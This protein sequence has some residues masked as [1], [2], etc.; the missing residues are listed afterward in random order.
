M[1]EAATTPRVPFVFMIESP[2]DEDL[3]NGDYEGHGLLGAQ[4][5]TGCRST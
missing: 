4:S 1:A 3:L 2:N 5:Q